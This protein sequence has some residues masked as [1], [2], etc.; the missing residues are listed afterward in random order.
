[1]LNM[2]LFLFLF[3]LFLCSFSIIV[4]ADDNYNQYKIKSKENHGILFGK[5]LSI[6]DCFSSERFGIYIFN[7]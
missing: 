4:F 2:K 6:D 5:S 7:F 1:M 3:L